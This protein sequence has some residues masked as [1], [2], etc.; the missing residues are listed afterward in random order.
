MC[1]HPLAS[2]RGSARFADFLR[3]LA[4]MQLHSISF[5][6]FQILISYSCVRPVSGS[7]VPDQLSVAHANRSGESSMKRMSL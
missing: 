6:S 5:V 1:L 2:V 4:S 7:R 3:Q